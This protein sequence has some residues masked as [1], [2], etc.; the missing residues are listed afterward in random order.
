MSVKR[1]EETDD[2]HGRCSG[3]NGR[4]TNQVAEEHRHIVVALR[5]DRFAWTTD[6]ERHR[7]EHHPKTPKRHQTHTHTK[8]N[9]NKGRE[10]S[11]IRPVYK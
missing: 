4:E 5:L 8:I 3:A 9:I 1:L 7:Q 10:T 6:S 2:F 11:A